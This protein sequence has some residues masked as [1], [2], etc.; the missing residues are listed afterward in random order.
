[1]SHLNINGVD[2]PLDHVYVKSRT[3]NLFDGIIGVDNGLFNWNGEVSENNNYAIS[4]YIP[5]ESS[6]AYTYHF[7]HNIAENNRTTYSICGYDSNKNV[8]SPLTLNRIT[9]IRDYDIVFTTQANTAYIRI[10][11]KK[12][13]D[14][15]LMLNTGPTALPYVPYLITK[16][17]WE[18]R[19][20]V[21]LHGLTNPLCGIDTYKDTLDLSTG[22]LTRYIMK[23]VLTGNETWI[24]W[25][26]NYYSNALDTLAINASPCFCTHFINS[27]T[28]GINI[29]ANASKLKIARTAVSDFV[30]DVEG[31]KQWLAAQYSTG[32][33]VTVW[34]V[35]TTPETEQITVPSNLTGIVEGYLTQGST[36]SPT[37]PVYPTANGTLEQDGTYSLDTG[38]YAIAWGRA[39]TFIGT[40]SISA[41]CYGLPVK[42]WEIDGN[43]QQTGTPTPDNPV[44]PEIVGMRT[45]NLINVY[46]NDTSNGY[47]NRALMRKDGS[48]YTPSSSIISEYQPI[49]ESITYTL[50]TGGNTGNDQ[51]ICFYTSDKQFISGV[52]YENRTIITFTTPQGARYFRCTIMRT[53]TDTESYKQT[54]LNAGSTPLPYEPYGYKIP[55]TCAGQTVPVYLGQVQTVRRIRKLV[56]DGAENWGLNTSGQLPFFY[57][58][59]ADTSITGTT[60]ISTHFP[61][62]T[63]GQ[64]TIEI[65]I[66]LGGDAQL[67]VRPVD[68]TSYT[69]NS[70]KVWLSTNQPSVWYVLANEQTGIVNEPIAKIGDYADTLTS[71]QAGVILSTNDG[72]TTI[73]VDTALAPSRFEIKV[74][75]KPIHYGFKID[76]A[77]SDPSNAVIYTHDAV[78]MTPAGMDFT[79]GVFNYGSWENVWFIKN[80]RPVMLNFDGTEAYDLDPND[81][82]KKLDGTPSDIADSTKNMN[83]MI[84]FPTVWIKRTDDGSYNYIEISDRQLDSDFHAYAHENA[85]GVVKPYI[86]LPIYKGS[87]VDG[88][89]RSIS[90]VKPQSNTTAQREVDTASA[91]G[92]GWQIWDYTSKEMLCELL[93]LISKS[94]D[95]QDKFGQGHSTGGSSASDFLDCGT[96]NDKGKFFGYSA[97]TS[98]VKCFGM[99]ALWAERWD[100]ELGLILDAGIYKIKEHPAYSLT[101]E[102]YTAISTSV[103][104]CPT[105]NGYIETEVSTQFGG[106][107]TVV[108]GTPSTYY[109]DYFYQYQSGV[110]VALR[111]GDC[112]GGANAG[113]RYVYVANAASFSYWNRGAS[114]VY[115]PI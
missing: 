76:K 48:I 88:K 56:L 10:N 73:S 8:I 15:D 74:H 89:L 90:G 94:L 49:N 43:S 66:G 101:G 114:P 72:N 12:P 57:M 9:E 93:T 100:R 60:V 1:M 35:L 109:C 50:N 83:A 6:T 55:I 110:F 7:Y 81:Y 16:E 103:A 20:R 32:H 29:G 99:E 96:L 77:V 21:I 31:L 84:A 58:P 36:P 107:P 79:N 4:N 87:I 63:V 51:S 38:A 46:A 98:Q 37:S 45:R 115:K 113:L 42:S 30:Q 92:T 61:S 78:T 26:N 67:R 75:A 112:S 41:R 44:M 102:G 18:A 52:A 25:N 14:E 65:G 95:T 11:W 53:Q 64:K 91:L 22:T 97:T 80:A 70:W 39:D 24:V 69:L 104:K 40:D 59:L 54:M 2:K 71:E 3:E 5:V 34:Y 27:S 106:L 19:T 33:P 47:I 68:P 108:G 13:Y 17:A 28:S 62:A 105:S 23:L 85:N 111:G 86:Y 82:S